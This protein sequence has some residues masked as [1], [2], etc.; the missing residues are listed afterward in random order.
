MVWELRVCFGWFW[1]F[2]L[3]LNGFGLVLGSV[4]FGLV[5]VFVLF[6]FLGLRLLVS[7][8]W[9]FLD[10]FLCFESCFL[11]WLPFPLYESGV[12]VA[13]VVVVVLLLLLLIFLQQLEKLGFLPIK[14]RGGLEQQPET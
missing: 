3:F 14:L 4:G 11:S 13:A 5:L 2:V 12:V 9:Y 10:M 6:W 7:L 8:F 1:G